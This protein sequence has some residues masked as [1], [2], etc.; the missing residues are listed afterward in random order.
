MRGFVFIT[1]LAL[2][3]SLLTAQLNQT[4]ASIDDPNFSIFRDRPKDCPPCFN[5]N[6]EEFQCKQF[7]NCS[8]T[9]GRC[10]CPPG[11]GGLDCAEPL[12]DSLAKGTHRRVRGKNEAD[13]KCDDG[14]EGIN[15]NVCKTN[16][17]CGPLVAD[18]S[19]AV[20]YREGV[21]QKENFQNCMITNRKII[22]QLAPQIP[23]ATFS[24]NAERGECNFQCTLVTNIVPVRSC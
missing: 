14:W 21:V 15:C 18:K 6:L 3:P 13:C 7:A 9:S 12:C 19:R 11:F 10:S 4:T 8:S 23:E 17:A 1:A 24:C 2:L 22:S 16:Q 20:C 5:C